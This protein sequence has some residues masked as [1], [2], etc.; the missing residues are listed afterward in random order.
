MYRYFCLNLYLLRV[1]QLRLLLILRLWL[2]LIAFQQVS[3]KL[4]ILQVWI[5]LLHS[6]LVKRI[7]HS[8]PIVGQFD[9]E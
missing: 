8:A 1:F 2:L 4:L 5:R 3:E 7:V 6:L 9:C